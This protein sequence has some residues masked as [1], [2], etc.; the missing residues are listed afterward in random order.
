[1]IM[2]KV[3]Q[4]QIN[5]KDFC[6]TKSQKSIHFSIKTIDFWPLVPQKSY[7][8]SSINDDVYQK[9]VKKTQLI[10]KRESNYNDF[11]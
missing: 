6:A 11:F 9:I 4:F 3:K 10:F 2:K 5:F 1:M 7:V 8:E